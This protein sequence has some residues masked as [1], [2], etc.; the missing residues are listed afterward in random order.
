MASDTYGLRR[1]TEGRRTRSTLGTTLYPAASDKGHSRKTFV[2]CIAVA[3]PPLSYHDLQLCEFKT[4]NRHEPSSAVGVLCACKL[5]TGIP[6]PSGVG[7]PIPIPSTNERWKKGHVTCRAADRCDQ[8]PA[9]R[10][11][12][13]GRT[14]ADADVGLTDEG[15]EVRRARRRGWKGTREGVRRQEEG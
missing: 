14:D 1:R 9:K 6:F 13:N 3:S 11:V 2:V 4:F 5:W 12:V 10:R 8:W 7:S 15:E